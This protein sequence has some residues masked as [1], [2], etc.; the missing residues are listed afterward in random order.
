MYSKIHSNLA[1]QRIYFNQI[2]KGEK[3]EEYDA[4]TNYYVEAHFC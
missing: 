4:F 3:T 2:L 1:L